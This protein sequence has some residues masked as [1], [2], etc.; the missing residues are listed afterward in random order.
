MGGA[1]PSDRINATKQDG[2]EFPSLLEKQIVVSHPP[3]PPRLIGKA[4]KRLGPPRS[5]RRTLCR[6]FLAPPKRPVKLV[7]S[8]RTVSK[9]VASPAGERPPHE[10]QSRASGD[11]N[12]GTE[13]SR[14]PLALPGAPAKVGAQFGAHLFQNSSQFV[15]IGSRRS[16]LSD[17]S[18]TRINSG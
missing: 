7:L 10:A 8:L 6:T 11:H 17:C 3:H 16:P 12:Q 5:L 1:P 4:S 15:T 9:I 13:T 18:Q 2:Q 14:G